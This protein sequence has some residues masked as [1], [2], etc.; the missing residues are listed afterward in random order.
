M[1]ARARSRLLVVLPSAF[2]LGALA[3]GKDSPANPPGTP[4]SLAAASPQTLE[5]SAARAIDAGATVVV[6]DGNGKP[7]AGVPVTFTAAPGA[8]TVETPAARTDQRGIAFSGKWTLGKA[9]GTQRLVAR[10]ARLDSIAFLATVSP[11]APASISAMNLAAANGTVGT[12]V[13]TPPSVVVRDDYGNPVSGVPVT[14]AVRTG[15]G[16]ATGTERVTD[17]QGRAA[18]GALKLGMRSGPQEI[19]V[20]V[21]GLPEA[22]LTV[23][24]LAGPAQVVRLVAGSDQIAYVGSALDIAPRISARDAYNNPVARRAVTARVTQGGGTL[25]GDIMTDDAGV[26]TVGR[27]AMG[28]AEGLNAVA[29]EV[30]GLPLTVYAKAVPVSGFDIQFR[31]LSHVTTRQREAF[32]RSAAR[33]KKVISGDVADTRAVSSSFCGVDGTALNEVVDDLI[34]FVTIDS[35]DGAG[36]VLGSAGPC[37]IRSADGIPVVGAMRFDRDDVAQLETQDRFADVVLH[38]IGHILGLGTLWKYRGFLEGAGGSDPFYVG[39]SARSGFVSAGGATYAG[40][41]VPVENTGGP[42][43][44]EGHWR[45]SVLNTEVMTGFVEAPGVRMP[46]SLTTVGALED[47]GYHITVW[48][49]DPYTYGMS[50]LLSGA[51]PR[52]S[53]GPDRELIEVPF[54]PPEVIGAG[55]QRTSISAQVVRPPSRQRRVARAAPRPVQELEVRRQP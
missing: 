37:S 48:G 15:G 53:P 12:D 32:E 30:D 19:A 55:G 21:S 9:A 39:A 47:L 54:P 27:W 2:V 26:A 18:L 29:V 16:L 38:E 14:F 22:L 42:G 1:I 33:W 5:G 35:I 17:A 40:N 3:C 6:R 10:V 28:P 41:P 11:G 31:Y 4:A 23:T 25:V 36:Q 52:R 34:I 45:E 44:R 24:A 7:L 50:P 20:Q 13:A 46:L 8:G 43:T 51:L 49:D